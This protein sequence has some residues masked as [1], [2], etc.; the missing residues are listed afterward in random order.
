M[1]SP[2]NG[3]QIVAPFTEHINA[4]AKE[5]RF[6]KEKVVRVITE[7][8]FYFG[9]VATVAAVVAFVASFLF[10]S[11]SMPTSFIVISQVIATAGMTLA[12]PAF[13]ATVSL[14]IQQQHKEHLQAKVT[15]IQKFS[16]KIKNDIE[17]RFLETED[18]FLDLKQ[19][20]MDATSARQPNQKIEQPIEEKEPELK[21]KAAKQAK[22][23]SIKNRKSIEVNE[24]VN[25]PEPV[26]QT[27]APENLPEKS[28]T[29]LEK[30]KDALNFF[31]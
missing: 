14:K 3:S 5:G 2:V 6:A 29:T 22:R 24:V 10:A 27:T 31:K 16:G 23:R 1:G 13:V 17:Q 12:L 25:H 19:K 28:K 9:A 11:L 21:G 18:R 15:A 30:M 7:A 8:T 20:K 4:P 26:L